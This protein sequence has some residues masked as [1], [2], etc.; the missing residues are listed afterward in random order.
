MQSVPSFNVSSLQP[1]GSGSRFVLLGGFIGSGRTTAVARLAKHA[2][3]RGLSMAALLN[4][5]GLSLVDSAWL[6]WERVR[7]QEVV[8]GCLGT[9]GTRLTAAVHR[10]GTDLLVAEPSGMCANLLYHAHQELGDAYRY[11]PVSVMVD[12]FV[13]RSVLSGSSAILS[14]GASA[15]YRQQLEEAD[16]I[17]LNKIDLLSAAERHD[18]E[19]LLA[20]E[21]PR[22]TVLK[23]SLLTGEGVDAWLERLMMFEAGPASLGGDPVVFGAAESRFAWLNCSLQLS[24]IKGFDAHQVMQFIASMLRGHV[25]QRGAQLAHLKMFLETEY[26]PRECVQLH[27]LP[28]QVNPEISAELSEPVESGRLWINVRAECIPDLLNNATNLALT[29]ASEHFKHLF[30]RIENLEHFRPQ[31]GIPMQAV[32]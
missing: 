31:P 21:F 17:V 19:A 7:V 22:S 30:V 28:G 18:L 15:L 9:Q 24:S 20:S 1:K 8:G 16:L 23:I 14:D 4:D 12:P 27:Q 26:G 5:R 11:A 32:A 29:Q 6:K 10:A 13:A 2:Q 3:T 25:E